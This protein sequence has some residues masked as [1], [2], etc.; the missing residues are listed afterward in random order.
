MLERKRLKFGEIFVVPDKGKAPQLHC[1]LFHLLLP[2]PA[3]HTGSAQE[4]LKET[5]FH[6]HRGHPELQTCSGAEQ[7]PG[8]GVVDVAFVHIFSPAAF[9]LPFQGV[10]FRKLNS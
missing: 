2:C 6:K 7:L 3:P 5:D 9:D 1:A 4:T 8:W 10:H